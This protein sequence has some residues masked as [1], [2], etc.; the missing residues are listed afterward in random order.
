M[1]LV[2]LVISLSL[3]LHQR[4]GVCT[5]E[6]TGAAC[7]FPP[8]VFPR[9]SSTSVSVCERKQQMESLEVLRTLMMSSEAEQRVH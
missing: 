7:S 4:P 2:L 3:R 9:S 6:L 8:R 1:L 5:G